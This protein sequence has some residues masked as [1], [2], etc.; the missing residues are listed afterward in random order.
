MLL[1]QEYLEESISTNPPGDILLR[2]VSVL[3][4]L[5][6]SVAFSSG[7][8]IAIMSHR[9]GE[10]YPPVYD[11]TGDSV[12]WMHCPLS[13]EEKISEIWVVRHNNKYLN[14]GISSLIASLNYY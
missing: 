13:N 8:I 1:Q 10:Q 4:A 12:V 5:T 3:N 6:I 2:H 9:Q 7:R 11:K 14:F